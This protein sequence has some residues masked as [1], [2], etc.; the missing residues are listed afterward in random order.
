MKKV[1]RPYLETE[2]VKIK[3]KE[4]KI[5]YCSYC[6][7]PNPI[8]E[9]PKSNWINGENLDR[10]KFPCFCSYKI[11]KDD[12]LFY[13]E[14]DINWRNGHCWY[15]LQELKQMNKEFSAIRF[16]ITNDSLKEIIQDYDI[17]ILKGKIIIFKEGK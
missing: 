8:M 10:I 12:S 1:S 7:K 2:V 17:H 11:P 4:A 9:K 16:F 6:G 5:E 14:L 3:I 15:E 13:G